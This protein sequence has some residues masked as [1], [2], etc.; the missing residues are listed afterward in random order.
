[1]CGRFALTATPREVEQLFDIAGLEPF[2]ERYNIAPTQPIC[3]VR[4][5][6][7]GREGAL[8]RWGLVPHWVKDPA[9][10][11]LLINARSE[12]ALEKPAFRTAMRH[13]RCLIPASGFYEWH[14]QDTGKQPYW[15]APAD[16]KPVAFAGIWETWMGKDGSEIDTAAFL[17]TS[18]NASLSVIHHRMPVIIHPGDYGQWIDP[19][20]DAKEVVGLLRAAPNDF[21]A[22]IPVSNRVNSARNDGPD[23]Q[24]KID[25]VDAQGSGSGGRNK[26]KESEPGIHEKPKA[27]AD[28]QMDLF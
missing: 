21:F 26:L 10:F 27:S 17:T 14:R 25:L 20:V 8:V 3:I 2:P 16:G 15:I 19:F 18:A 28:D 4:T 23:L 9:S 24:K 1:M 5:G 6:G 11:S 13:R 7:V 12:T 22:A